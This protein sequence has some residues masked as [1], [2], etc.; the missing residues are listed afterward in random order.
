M[1][2]KYYLLGKLMVQRGFVGSK[3]NLP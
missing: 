1:G 3:A 2:V